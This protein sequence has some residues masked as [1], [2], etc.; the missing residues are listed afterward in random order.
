MPFTPATARIAAKK[1]NAARKKR[2]P[3]GMASGIPAQPPSSIES[4]TQPGTQTPGSDADAFTRAAGAAPSQPTGGASA[5]GPVTEQEKAQARGLLK[6][7]HAIAESALEGRLQQVAGG[8]GKLDDAYLSK[9]GADEAAAELM[10]AHVGHARPEL[11][12]AVALGPVIFSLAGRAYDK[13][14]QTRAARPQ[15]ARRAGEERP[16]LRPQGIGENEPGPE[17]LGF[18]RP[19]AH[20]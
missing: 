17:R 4:E 5:D 20:T 9:T 8:D 18:V 16:D 3:S 19:G 13:W 12:L 15:P 11:R 6:T 2:F 7:L 10:R 1:A 14:L